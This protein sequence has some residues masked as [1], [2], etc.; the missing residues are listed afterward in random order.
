MIDTAV[1]TLFVEACTAL[2]QYGALNEDLSIA[3][4]EQSQRLAGIDTKIFLESYLLVLNA[5]SSFRG[6]EIEPKDLPNKIQ[7]FG[8]ARLAIGEVMRQRHYH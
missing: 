2:I 7:D 8:K 5:T 6:R 3:S 4:E 1:D